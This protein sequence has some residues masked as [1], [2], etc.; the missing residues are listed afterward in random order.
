MNI[1]H[2]LP[3]TVSGFHLQNLIDDFV[4]DENAALPSDSEILRNLDWQKPFRRIS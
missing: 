2:I 1:L 3:I 4:F